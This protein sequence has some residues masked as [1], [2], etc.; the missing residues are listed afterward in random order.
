MSVQNAYNSWAE[1]YDS[2]DNKT[3]DLEAIALRKV[4]SAVDFSSVLEIGCGTGKNTTWFAERCRKVTAVDFSEEMLEKAREKLT[5]DHVEFCIADIKSPWTFCA[6]T[7]EL[8]SFSLVL[9]HINNLDTI[10]QQASDSLAPNGH[11]YL[12]ELHPFKQYTGSKARF[13]TADGE[14]VVDCFDHHISDFVYAAQKAGLEIA[15]VEELFD[16]EERSGVPRILALLFK[17]GSAK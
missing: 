10:F 14:Q 7:Y 5:A 12:G 11:V 16:D 8:V 15:G 4:L 2:N 6:T 9:E 13:A 3:R 1:Q 17:N